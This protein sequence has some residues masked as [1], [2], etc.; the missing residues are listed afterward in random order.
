MQSD[1]VMI[2]DSGDEIYVWIGQD[3]SQD[4][5]EKGLVLAKKYLNTDPT[6]RD[7]SNTLIF[8]VKEGEEPS[9]FTCIFPGWA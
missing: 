9:S 2:L 3:A 5:K 8:K 6:E 7:E 4:E 1:D